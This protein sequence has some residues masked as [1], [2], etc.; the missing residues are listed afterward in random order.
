MTPPE[1]MRSVRP[2]SVPIFVRS[3]FFP[4]TR[5]VGVPSMLYLS[6]VSVPSVT[7]LAYRPS[8]TAASNSAETSVETPAFVA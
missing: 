6:R 4:A 8:L 3:T 1:L 5:T 7:Q 2:V